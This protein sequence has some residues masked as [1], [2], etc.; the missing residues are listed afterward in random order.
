MTVVFEGGGA[1]LL[2]LMHPE[3]PKATGRR[4]SRERTR[5]LR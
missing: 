5:V 2:L 4:I 3:T 1:G